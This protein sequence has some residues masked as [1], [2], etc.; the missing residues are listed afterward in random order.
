MSSVQPTSS[1]PA[2]PARSPFP[3]AALWLAGCY[4]VS[5]GPILRGIYGS[6][7]DE[8][9]NMEHGVLVPFVIAFALHQMLP[10]LRAIPDAPSR[11]GLLLLAVAFL[12]AWVGTLAQW[13]FVARTALP[14]SVAGAV[15]YWK[16]TRYLRAL[17]YPLLLSLLMITPPTFLYNRLTLQLQ[18]L[19]SFLAEH[20]LETLGFSVLREGNILELVGEKLA[21]E[22]ACSGIKSL[23]T[24]TFFAL[25]YVYFLVPGTRHRAIL[26]LS[27]VPIA[28]TANAF[29]IVL[30]GVVGQYDRQLAHSVFHDISGYVILLFSGM[31]FLCVHLLA[32]RLDSTRSVV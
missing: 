26:L 21:V 3:Y 9:A 28:I 7:F 32:S 24:L 29:R 20:S 16:G 8:F 2:L 15:L 23:I 10:K 22:E 1:A 18:L 30:T 27:V 4:A 12:Q 6:W 11:W 5:F 19:A 13:T 14:V 17:A 31:L 25:V